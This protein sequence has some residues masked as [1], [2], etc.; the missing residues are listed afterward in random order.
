MPKVLSTKPY[1]M[2][3]FY[4]WIL[5]SDLTPHVI[6]DTTYPRV[7]VPKNYIEDGRIILNISPEATDQL[8]IGNE[9][10]EFSASFD[11]AIERISFPIAA[12]LAIYAQENGKG[13][14]FSEEEDD[15]GG[16][17]GEGSPPMIESPVEGKPTK[18]PHL[19]VVK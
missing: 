4:D 11:Q 14:V 8:A 10:I 13:M 16:D 6:V 18:Y 5:D 2:R 19:R 12:V 17:D 15:D 7:K 1:L 3:A 9:W